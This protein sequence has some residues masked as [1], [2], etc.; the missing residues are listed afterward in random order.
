MG[1]GAS[2]LVLAGVIY[3]RRERLWD[4]FQ[5][6]IELAQ[7]VE[8]GYVCASYQASDTMYCKRCD[9]V[10]D[11]NDSDPPKCKPS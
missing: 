5:H 3:W 10:W 9:L 6:S 2:L 7:N 4:F 11:T 8:R 1:W